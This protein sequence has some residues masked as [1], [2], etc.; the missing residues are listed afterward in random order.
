MT[1]YFLKEKGF[2]LVKMLDAIRICQIQKYLGVVGV[3]ISKKPD[4]T[5]M[6]SLYS[7]HTF[8]C[9]KK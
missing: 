1:S 4:T 7:Y 3:M 5:P 6:H 8:T 2:F 9:I